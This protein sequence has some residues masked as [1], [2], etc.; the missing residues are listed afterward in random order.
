MK[1][2]RKLSLII[3]S[4]IS[5]VGL[6]C[7]V[8]LMTMYTKGEETPRIELD[9][10]VDSSTPDSAIAIDYNT[11]VGDFIIDENNIIIGFS[12]DGKTRMATAKNV[13]LKIPRVNEI[14][15]KAYE[16]FCSYTNIIDIDNSYEVPW[17]IYDEEAGANA[18]TIS[19]GAITAF[20]NS[21]K[22]KLGAS[23]SPIKTL[24]FPTPIKY[25]ASNTTT[26]YST[27]RITG[28]IGTS[29][30]NQESMLISAGVTFIGQ[31]ALKNDAK[32]TSIQNL[33]FA[34]GRKSVLYI[35]HMAFQRTLSLKTIV[36][37]AGVYLLQGARAFQENQNIENVYVASENNPYVT[38]FY[39][40][41]EGVLYTN[42]YTYTDA[43]NK[44]EDNFNIYQQLVYVPSKYTDKTG[45]NSFDF[46][47]AHTTEIGKYAFVGS[48]ITT[49]HIPDRIT[50]ID[51]Y[52]M[53]YSNLQA[54]CLPSNAEFKDYVLGEKATEVPKL[55]VVIAP[56]PQAY[57]AYSKL[58]KNTVLTSKLS[59]EIN[60][61]YEKNG[62][63]IQTDTVLFGENFYNYVKTENGDYEVG[64][65]NLPQDTTWYFGKTG[66]E[67]LVISNTNFKDFLSGTLQGASYYSHTT[68]GDKQVGIMYK[69]ITLTDT[70]TEMA[71]INK[72]VVAPEFQPNV[73][74]MVYGKELP[75]LTV[76]F[77]Y[78]GFN[79]NALFSGYDS[80]RMKYS[81]T[82]T[83][84]LKNINGE[85]RIFHAGT[86]VITVGINDLISDYTFSGT[87]N[88]QSID[89]NVSVL[90]YRIVVLE[91]Q[92]NLPNDGNYILIEEES[93]LTEAI[94][95]FENNYWYTAQ[96]SKLDETSMKIV[97]LSSG[98]LPQKDGSYF[99]KLTL[100]DKDGNIKWRYGD[101]STILA[102]NE[103]EI[104][105]LINT[106]PVL[107]PPVLKGQDAEAR[108]LET[109]FTGQEIP[110][111]NLFESFL[112]KAVSVKITHNNQEITSIYDSSDIPYIVTVQPIGDYKWYGQTDETKQN[113]PIDYKIY[114]R[115]K[116]VLKPS[117]Y[118]LALD[119][120]M[121][122]PYEYPV[123][124][125]NTFFYSILGY[126]T[127]KSD[128]PA[129]YSATLPT[130]PGV[131]YVYITLND[132]KNSSW[133][134]TTTTPVIVTF[135]IQQKV[136]VP[137]INKSSEY[138]YKASSF[139]Y[140]NILSNYVSDAYIITLSSYKDCN[141]TMGTIPT[142][143]K[144]AGTYTL[145]FTLN[146]GYIWAKTFNETLTITITQKEVTISGT[147]SYT[148]A[149]GSSKQL[150]RTISATSLGFIVTG[151]F[152]I[153]TDFSVIVS[154][155]LTNEM[156]SV[157]SHSVTTVTATLPD[158]YAN[159]YKLNG[160]PNGLTFVVTP[161]V[162]DVDFENISSHT[163]TGTGY[164]PAITFKDKNT[165]Q[166]LKLAEGVD[167][168]LSFSQKINETWGE[169]FTSLPIHVGDYK[170]LVTILNS[171]Y[172]LAEN[173]S[174]EKEYSISKATIT[175]TGFEHYET[176]P[177]IYDGTNEHTYPAVYSSTVT[178]ELSKIEVK[179]TT[180]SAN[181]GT[182]SS[183]EV[184]ILYEANAF[185]DFTI[186]R[187]VNA[188]FSIT[189]SKAGVR[190]GALSSLPYIGYLGANGYYKESDLDISL[191][192]VNEGTP[193]TTAILTYQNNSIGTNLKNA[194][195]YGLTLTLTDSVNY[196]FQEGTGSTEFTFD[197]TTPSNR[198]S[199]SWNFE[200]TK[201]QFNAMVN[202]QTASV[203]Y[204]AASQEAD[205]IF[206]LAT[207]TEW[208]TLTGLGY[209][210]EYYT[211]SSL[212]TVVLG[213]PID[214]GTYYVKLILDD[215]TKA[216]FTL[217][218]SNTNNRI[219]RITKKALEVSSHTYNEKFNGTTHFD[220]LDNLTILNLP[221]ADTQTELKINITT[222]SM[223]VGTYKTSD[224]SATIEFSG[225]NTE[226]YILRLA[227]DAEII[228]YI[229]KTEV[230]VEWLFEGSLIATNKR[231]SYTGIDLSSSLN[232]S[233]TSVSGIHV[234][235]AIEIKL[236][237]LL[238]PLENAG[239]YSLSAIF[240]SGSG[241][242]ASNYTLS[243]QTITFIIEP[244]QI[245]KSHL[246]A[247]T[248]INTASEAGGRN[249]VGGT[250][251]LDVDGT[252]KE[253]TGTN[254]FAK[255]RGDTI[256]NTIELGSLIG[257]PY[258]GIKVDGYQENRK[259]L[260]GEYKAQVQLSLKNNNYIWSSELNPTEG[261]IT[262]E[263]DWYIV[264]FT[265]G[266]KT[267]FSTAGWVFGSSTVEF[268]APVPELG[269]KEDLRYTLT[270]QKNR[271]ENIYISKFSD[272]R[273]WLNSSTPA[274]DWVL[275]VIVPA[276]DGKI[277]GV[278]VHYDGR[279]IETSFVVSPAELV[280]ENKT[281]INGK[282]FTHIYNGTAQY[283]GDVTPNITLV[284]P[285]RTGGWADT[286]YN[287]YYATLE[288]IKWGY[289]STRTGT[290]Y[291]NTE[292]WAGAPIRVKLDGTYKIYYTLSALNHKNYAPNDA[293]FDV[294]ISPYQIQPTI[295]SKTESVLYTNHTLSWTYGY[296]F[297]LEDILI[298]PDQ[299]F[300]VE[301]GLGRGEN[302]KDLI[303]YKHHFLDSNGKTV[304]QL[305]A[306]NYRLI[307]EI[308]EQAEARNN[309]RN[310]TLGDNGYSIDVEIAQKELDA[311]E[312]IERVYTG[313]VWEY[314]VAK[315]EV[316]EV[317]SYSG[318]RIQV[319][320]YIVT[321]R[322]KDAHTSNYVWKNKN[323]ATLSI[324]PATVNLTISLPGS[325]VYNSLSHPLTLSFAQGSESKTLRRGTDFTLSFVGELSGEISTDP[326]NA[327]VYAVNL[328]LSD[329]Y[330]LGTTH[331]PTGF[332][333][334]KTAVQGSFTITKA[335][336][337]ISP[338]ITHDHY[339]S[340]TD[341]NADHTFF[342]THYSIVNIQTNGVIPNLS[343]EVSVTYLGENSETTLL[344]ASVYTLSYELIGLGKQNFT[345]VNGISTEI[346]EDEIE[347]QK[348]K[349]SYSLADKS[350]VFNQSAQT[351][352][353]V[354]HNLCDTKALP[355]VSEYTV[356]YKKNSKVEE[357]VEVGTYSIFVEL[358]ADA[359]KNFE[360]EVGELSVLM[361]P[362][363]IVTHI[364]SSTIYNGEV[365][366]PTISFTWNGN[367]NLTLAETDYIVS[368]EGDDLNAEGLPLHANQYTVN[369]EMTN[370]N[371]VIRSGHETSTF[372]IKPA[373]VTFRTGTYTYSGEAQ[374]V[375]PA[376]VNNIHTN[377]CPS[378]WKIVSYKDS[379]DIE[380]NSADFK[381]VG[382][383]HI[384]IELTG[385]DAQ[386]FILKSDSYI[387]NII[388]A[389]IRNVVWKEGNTIL[390][391][392]ATNLGYKKSEYQ[393][394]ATGSYGEGKTVDLIVS[395]SEGESKLLN[396]GRYVLTVSL[397][398]TNHNF[399]AL[400]ETY[401]LNITKAIVELN[402][403]DKEKEYTAEVQSVTIDFI[404]NY[405]PEISDYTVTYQLGDYTSSI[406]AT[407]VGSYTIMV[408]FSENGN[409]VFAQDAL[410]SSDTFVI[411]KAII[412]FEV[413]KSIYN[414]NGQNANIGFTWREG[415]ALALVKDVDY[416]IIYK[417]SSLVDGLPKN[418]GQYSFTL[419]LK[420]TYTD[421]YQFDLASGTMEI[422]PKELTVT[423]D[424]IY[425][426]TYGEAGTSR[427]K[428]IQDILNL[429]L[430][431]VITDDVV[432]ANI[433]F[434]ITNKKT[435]KTYTDVIGTL[436]LTGA[437]KGNY[438]L[439]NETIAIT[440]IIEKRAITLSGTG[441]HSEAYGNPAGLTRTFNAR[442]MGL[443]LGNV[444]GEDATA[445]TLNLTFSLP[446][447]DVD[448]YT[449]DSNITATLVD[450]DIAANYSI[451]V[452]DID[453]TIVFEIYAAEV[454]LQFSALEHTY[455]NQSYTPALQFIAGTNN[456]YGALPTV[457]EQT[458]TYQIKN[459]ENLASAP[460]SVGNYVVTISLNNNFIIEGSNTSDYKIIERLVYVNGIRLAPN[461]AAGWVY[462][463]TIHEATYAAIYSNY[464][465]T[466]DPE[467]Q[468]VLKSSSA[469]AGVYE[470]LTPVRY[471]SK[472][473]I[474]YKYVLG[475][476]ANL[477]L[478]ISKTEISISKLPITKPY[479][480]YLEN[481]G[482]YSEASLKNEIEI[483]VKNSQI[484]V[485]AYTLTY[486]K[487]YTYSQI[488]NHLMNVDTYHLKIELSD[489]NNFT[490]EQ[491]S[492]L[493]DLLSYTEEV[494]NRTSA[495]WNFNIS[496]AEI[497]A[498]IADASKKVVYSSNPV[499]PDVIFK[500]N[501]SE[502]WGNLKEN[503]SYSLKYYLDSARENEVSEA[504]NA[505]TYYVRLNLN[506]TNYTLVLS[507]PTNRV[508]EITQR[509]LL[510]TSVPAKPFGWVYDT[511]NK[512][513]FTIYP[514]ETGLGATVQNVVSYDDIKVL[515]QLTANEA[516]VGTYD[517][518]GGKLVATYSLEGT[519]CQNYTIR[520]ADDDNLTLNITQ[521]KAS[522]SWMFNSS[523]ILTEHRFTYNGAGR[524]NLIIPTITCLATGLNQ[525]VNKLV[526]K[527]NSI[528]ETMIDAGTYVLTAE[529]DNANYELE[530]DE[531]TVYVDPYTIESSV[532]TDLLWVN[533]NANNRLL[534]SGTY[535]IDDTISKTG[536]NA[537]AKFRKTEN[538]I[539]LNIIRDSLAERALH[540]L[541]YTGNK[542]TALGEYTARVQIELSSTNYAWS[543]D[544]SND[545]IDFDSPTQTITLKKVWYI[546]NFNNGLKT[547]FS[548][549]NK[550]VYGDIV[551][552]GVTYTVPE[553]EHISS[554]SSL[555]Y[556]L[557]GVG[558]SF[559][560][561]EFSRLEDYL[562]TSIP[563][564]TYS[565][566][567][568][569][570]LYHGTIEE[571]GIDVEVE[572]EAFEVVFSF[573]VHRG[574]IT[575]EDGIDEKTYTH[576]YD[577]KAHYFTTT[578]T[579]TLVNNQASNRQGGWAD[580]IYDS[581]YQEEAVFKYNNVSNGNYY[582]ENTESWLSTGAPIH[583]K[584]TGGTRTNYKIYYSIEA[585]NYEN[586]SNS[587]N[588]E[589]HYFYVNIE[590]KEIHLAFAGNNNVSYLDNTLSWTYN[591]S[592]SRGDIEIQANGVLL[593]DNL[594]FAYTF[595]NTLNSTDVYRGNTGLE[596]SRNNLP[597]NAGTYTLDVVL[598][599]YV[600]SLNNN[601]DY[602]LDKV[603]QLNATI[604]KFEI[605][606]PEDKEVVYTGNQLSYSVSEGEIYQI[607]EYT[608]DRIN[609]GSCIVTFEI[610][611]QYQNNYT[612]KNNE[613]IANLIITPSKIIAVVS[614]TE[615]TYYDRQAKA[616]VAI[617][618]E[619][620][621]G[622]VIQVGSDAYSITY[623]GSMALPIY[624]N[625]Y[626]VVISL[627]DSNYELLSSKTDGFNISDDKRRVEGTYS[628]LKAR[629][630]IS[631][632]NTASDLIYKGSDYNTND[633]FFSSYFN[634]V[635]QR[636][637]GVVPLSSTGYQVT[638][639][640]GESLLDAKS[641][642]V[643]YTLI[644]DAKDNFII[645][646]ENNELTEWETT[647]EMKKAKI[648]AFSNNSYTYTGA[649][650][651]VSLD[652]VNTS[653]T[654]VIPKNALSITYSKGNET[655]FL[656]AGIYT[657]AIELN[658]LD[659]NNFDLKTDT[660]EIEM[661]KAEI[662]V[663]MVGTMYYTKEAQEA[664]LTFTLTGRNT[665]S[666]VN[667]TDYKV[668]Y[669]GA[670][671]TDNLPKNPNRYHVLV[672][673]LGNYEKNYKL[674]GNVE[675]E[676][677]ILKAQV[678][679][680]I[681]GSY[682]Y[683][684][685]VQE[686][687][688]RFA[689][690]NTTG[691]VPEHKALITYKKGAETTFLNAGTYTLEIALGEEDSKYYELLNTTLE[692]SMGKASLIHVSWDNINNLVYTGQEIEVTANAL[693]G[694]Q[695]TLPLNVE[696]E[697]N[698]SI[699]N[700]GTYHLTATHDNSNF[701]PFSEE[702][703]LT[704]S[705]AIARL[706]LKN[707]TSNYTQEK[708]SATIDFLGNLKPS[709]QDY[710]LLYTLGEYSS[711]TGAID[712]GEYTL[713]ITL[714]EN[715]N[716]RF[717]NGYVE[718]EVFTISPIEL[719]ITTYDAIYN[720]KPQDVKIQFETSYQDILSSEKINYQI[721]Y[722][723]EDLVEGKPKNAGTYQVIIALSESSRNYSFEEY[724]GT[725][726]ITQ[727]EMSIEVDGTYTY[728]GKPQ[729][730][731]F[732]MN[733]SL[734]PNVL[735]ENYTV[736]YKKGDET[737]FL[738][739][740]TYSVDF[741]LNDMDAKNY[742]IGTTEFSVT[743]NKADIDSLQW[744]EEKTLIYTGNPYS[745]TA[746]GVWGTAQTLPL[747]V[748]IQDDLEILNVGTYTLT[749]VYSNP[750]FNEFSA[751]EVFTVL[752]AT[753]SVEV[754]NDKHVYDGEEKSADIKLIGPLK[755]EEFS[756]MYSLNEYTSLTGAS[757]AG[758]Y[759]LTISL[760]NEGNFTFADG[761]STTRR[762]TIEKAVL[763]ANIT[764]DSYTGQTQTAKIS[765][766]PIQTDRP[767]VA[768]RFSLGVKT[769][770][771]DFVEG[772][773][774]IVGYTGDG[775]VNG[776][777]K[778][779]G[780]YLVTIEFISDKAKNYVIKGSV[781]GLYQKEYTI[782]KAVIYM[783]WNEEVDFADD[784]EVKTPYIYD[785]PWAD[786][787]I[788]IYKDAKGNIL[789]SEPEVG[790]EYTVEVQLKD[791]TNFELSGDVSKTF[792]IIP[793]SQADLTIYLWIILFLLIIIVLLIIVII[794]LIKKNNKRENHNSIL[795][796]PQ[797]E[798][799]VG[800][801]ADTTVEEEKEEVLNLD[802]PVEPE[803]E[804]DS[805]ED[806][807]EDDEENTALEA[808]EKP[809]LTLEEIEAIIQSY[810]D[811]YFDEWNQHA[812]DELDDKYD[813]IMKGLAYYQKR[814]RRTFRDRINKATP[815]VKDIFN[816]VK[817]E[818]MQYEGVTNRLTKY[819][820]VFYIGRRKIAKIS[821]T[822]KKIKVYLAADPEK[823]PEN[824]FPHKNLA[825]KKS[826]AGT[827]YYAL[828]RSN[829]SIRRVGKVY[830]DIMAEEGK[831]K[832]ENYEP[833]DHAI[834]YRFL[835]QA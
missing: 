417:G 145:K 138:V 520:L 150:S 819:Y 516:N 318:D 134:D 622:E 77:G 114:V 606:H 721:A 584:L 362:A 256:Y 702:I 222:A 368:Y 34:T 683:T 774:Y 358:T 690:P 395:I 650:Q 724:T 525:T 552:S 530:N 1:K 467:L 3:L 388:P 790:G 732:K 718:T 505:G 685:L 631:K 666:L 142:E 104:N 618:F 616:G 226:N 250:Y 687:T 727:A 181:A 763:E 23:L 416:E 415:E 613:H 87:Y 141:G 79:M 32:N 83:K 144:N 74:E 127:T 251:T 775:L 554:G 770:S 25:Y 793:V 185:T 742:Y 90:Q 502:T 29:I 734:N 404:G 762:F 482:Y 755:P 485:P 514:N 208:D 462:D 753:I 112:V 471:I 356:S 703:S 662:S 418:V 136:E 501:N 470:N 486:Q 713:T 53:R 66:T 93:E 99:V 593:K 280:L 60:I 513:N 279:E 823:Y 543:K 452:S 597:S 19:S 480:G 41:Y 771:L 378:S 347:I 258:A 680:S 788:V 285:E 720:G 497:N 68:I 30:K 478:S 24:I 219:F 9:G 499:T 657:L 506:S 276:F 758:E 301:D 203:E 533:V 664:H 799:P 170:V 54:I 511:T 295:S 483:G 677:I 197:S 595:T 361:S 488:D 676:L 704:V 189:I 273:E 752:P 353:L 567:V 641:Y 738:N 275:T 4:T 18:F 370:K 773:D 227:S 270:N 20:S 207:S 553:A 80:S 350:Y 215:E 667:G 412:S 575:I 351:V 162:V 231:I 408:S 548:V 750:N 137:T 736:T 564:G 698:K 563:A 719:S 550:W 696:I 316:Y 566:T 253:I 11:S 545:S 294:E 569:V 546:V 441:S 334:T 801:S 161:S 327:D 706:N 221:E 541:N 7:A 445:L 168:S 98:E 190:V 562:N 638:Y 630:S 36:F 239:S 401:T 341:Y 48:N 228:L 435:V 811:K 474:N 410:S 760:K 540:I 577:G 637:T 532:I 645:V 776:L 384:V 387:A 324:V 14:S 500:L 317:L 43:S 84:S 746:Q 184:E 708:Q 366:Q 453:A 654:S 293:F 785:G 428:S 174:L 166:V 47:N 487:D 656:N 498:R 627:K 573:E 195:I 284:E 777:P 521:A 235:L 288:T 117:D 349:V 274:G 725:F 611:S 684:G 730:V 254:A 298:T 767:A 262:Y 111:A 529:F 658:A 524:I 322:I 628:I 834:K 268:V 461:E 375:Q 8:P 405:Q 55:E 572:Y 600:A 135:T 2:F 311:P 38:Q 398:E 605:A 31:E 187:D 695:Q 438:T 139:L 379:S 120:T 515:I 149:Y 396:A 345:I 510:V 124:Y 148:E 194:N 130:T 661:A 691:V 635:N 561:S 699:L 659:R 163:Y 433:S 642:V 271:L 126:S 557:M 35:S 829:L 632:K 45:K 123:A 715:G 812:K 737:I 160:I 88:N 795:I 332:T 463:G 264:D 154:Y 608:G 143:I 682:T 110:I 509:E 508:F 768:H 491:N 729:N 804:E 731:I 741:H 592:L 365:Q 213:N 385:L 475:E 348:A 183:P 816:Q 333:A 153:D 326:I 574:S 72:H 672:E 446:S 252:P 152:A 17:N 182:Y 594:T 175:I 565:L 70:P 765:F 655:T 64:T 321:F 325:L 668:T 756:V 809:T 596:F 821:L 65:Y 198:K 220:N 479:I 369:I 44:I 210:L 241:V 786:M 129:D 494:G 140:Q 297:K 831:E 747:T 534:V 28:K 360:L 614:H 781:D 352:E 336:I 299:I 424:G 377:V 429:S 92:V 663:S 346:Y 176:N 759:I 442:Q 391:A 810:R 107:V 681:D 389:V 128:N 103:E 344:N 69:N 363:E 108:E 434:D 678:S 712:A 634:V 355:T 740:G 122:P 749:V 477:F 309:N 640:N 780:K 782:A 214:V 507:D 464:I 709:A 179:L 289:N 830:A 679:A 85:N 257:F 649:A 282:T 610:K 436:R 173:I 588:R 397:P 518:K 796:E 707:L 581:Y 601:C 165:N 621:S 323:T 306:S 206:K 792:N 437:D 705:Q 247:L 517:I 455:D 308:D 800:D 73:G 106:D 372:E 674:V 528:V 625:D 411:T 779:A 200:I 778:N 196:Y 133:N 204:S 585:E 647:I 783:V 769:N 536:T 61:S 211:D 414:G 523:T 259:A 794:M 503:I 744:N 115:P 86:Y 52:A 439:A 669:S 218:V 425:K 748:H 551:T 465:E 302:G 636:S 5:A 620:E 538:Q 100:K 426:E 789:N 371:Y 406:G 472:D 16:E 287:A 335:E 476:N 522:V 246:D 531:I 119:G 272:L 542:E 46:P 726:H 710:S 340:G 806:D 617:S 15:Y 420:S 828:V 199:A 582:T 413:E 234:N 39:V 431:G 205:V 212:T 12:E 300:T 697:G 458:F 278:D 319:A 701:V 178:E 808:E 590:P 535:K 172:E 225:Y 454:K 236:D 89:E 310:Y 626:T 367:T 390:P 526:K 694:N 716:F 113:E 338:S 40:T 59:Y 191:Q 490:F 91:R 312:D 249:L 57:E 570:P 466:N 754:T 432:S 549:P 82:G 373:E 643:K 665:L 803:A 576:T 407:T 559:S 329:N 652:L 447:L 751:E 393:I 686:I 558:R 131:Y 493:G 757:A 633:D 547:E 646:D 245:E 71:I 50:K 26:L 243:N 409:Y 386:N 305:Q 27:V 337:S 651:E 118:T 802:L 825:D 817:N 824:S 612:W 382:E 815:E 443:S 745:I 728:T 468:I 460:V 62:Q 456:E 216:N 156:L 402:V 688:P 331:L 496:P 240:S 430:S 832:K 105:L 56:S 380:I 579:V 805:E 354:F 342:S 267:N 660:L 555:T 283:L 589:N 343:T 835:S 735:P 421:N 544:I 639:N 766:S 797:K 75:E 604:N 689:N 615:A 233:F 449:I 202:P 512:K 261:K 230:E 359:S 159:N 21:F 609:V 315:E 307:L 537:F 457:A 711:T 624:S 403:T 97:P 571:N 167:Y 116:S 784:A 33:Y 495:L 814:A 303:T 296:D 248:W 260:K 598:G 764:F 63:I 224:S 787:L 578:P 392:N 157:G 423:G 450:S 177:W 286:A 328:S 265:N 671:L 209:T 132:T 833:I 217:V 171:N 313:E 739:S 374:T 291:S 820:D 673:L 201:A 244:Y 238:Q 180:S 743:M 381:N 586:Y 102:D 692:V 568:K 304:T 96:Y 192:V 10:S 629:I 330:V 155:T 158:A 164:Y 242:T 481:N 81:I 448:T 527:N 603:Y 444:L 772:V 364:S 292:V 277:E 237:G 519:D 818:F 76:I 383:Y 419:A 484:S 700:A 6:C 459:G 95:L 714:P 169:E 147:G 587:L 125:E 451:A 670:P 489:K 357:F 146:P 22:T 269:N 722:F 320:D 58:L 422:T 109:T 791:T 675:G 717:E 427:D 580:H 653:G 733:N 49:L 121:V 51:S 473:N 281:D 78:D 599:G 623:N 101:G 591:D 648:E 42:E 290:L 94:R 826:H 339:Y 223:N 376:F 619:N 583:V 560:T 693:W 602:V 761:Y 798:E 186:L 469:N 813:E 539:Q 255:Y 266:L 400:S 504:V 314:P 399:T 556:A 723:G 822:N 827:P 232:A 193:A 151:N 263:K 229:E 188:N 492:P 644:G 440:V 807:E 37:S 607:L 13:K 67:N 394:T